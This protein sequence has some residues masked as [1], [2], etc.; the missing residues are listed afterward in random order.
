MHFLVVLVD[1]WSVNAVA[2]QK[3]DY[4]CFVFFCLYPCFSHTYIER[5]LPCMAIA[6]HS[7]QV[8]GSCLSSSVEIIGHYS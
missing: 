6:P 4:F 1:S 2:S 5:N 8:D 7:F 3:C